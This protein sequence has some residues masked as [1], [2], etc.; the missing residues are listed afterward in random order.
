MSI[1]Y[2]N[3]PELSITWH[4]TPE[5]IHRAF[6]ESS[7]IEAGI[8]YEE[9]MSEGD[10][11]GEDEFGNEH[12]FDFVTVIEAIRDQ[13]VWGFMDSADH[14]IH[15]WRGDGASQE[16]IIHMLA[17]EIGHATGEGN[18]DPI[19]EEMRAEQFGR[20][21]RLAYQMMTESVDSKRD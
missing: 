16:L 6:W 2:P 3:P 5:S 18:L 20:V 11:C 12:V 19:Q 1:A 7:A 15:A 13:G 4:E 17:H 21:A 8:S 10:F 9:M 14:R